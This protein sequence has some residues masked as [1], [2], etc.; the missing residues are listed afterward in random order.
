M[1]LHNL[2]RATKIIYYSRNAKVTAI[3]YETKNIA[4]SS[5]HCSNRI[6]HWCLFTAN[7]HHTNF[8]WRWK[9]W[10]IKW[11]TKLEYPE[12]ISKFVLQCHNFKLS[13]IS[14]STFR[15]FGVAPRPNGSGPRSRSKE[16][17]REITAP[18]YIK[19]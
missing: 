3:I 18:F 17:W 11:K 10:R 14:I 2:F 9:T 15:T 19:N 12:K 13:F 1:T 6:N 8:Q 16:G 4:W 5:A 7:D